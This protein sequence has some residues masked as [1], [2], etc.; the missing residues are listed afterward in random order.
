MQPAIKTHR[1]VLFS[2]VEIGQEFLW[3]SYYLEDQNWGR[4]RSSRTADY[5]PFV[6]DKWSDIPRWGFWRQDE[7]VFVKR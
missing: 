3:G 6:N 4:K 1:E 2:E 7:L 5:R